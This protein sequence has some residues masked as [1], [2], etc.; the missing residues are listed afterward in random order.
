MARIALS[1]SSQVSALNKCERILCQIQ[2]EIRRNGTISISQLR[3]IGKLI[4]QVLIKIIASF[5]E[6]SI[7][8]ALLIT[9]ICHIKLGKLDIVISI[10]EAN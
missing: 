1:F 7:K 8:N 3:S 6:L 2:R 5:R 9:I 4:R 10:D